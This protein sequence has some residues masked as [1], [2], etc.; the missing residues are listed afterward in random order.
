[1]DGTCTISTWEG[2]A[3][4]QRRQATTQVRRAWDSAFTQTSGPVAGLRWHV[5]HRTWAGRTA[6]ACCHSR[7]AYLPSRLPPTFAPTPTCA[8]ILGGHRFLHAPACPGSERTLDGTALA[9]LILPGCY[10]D[11]LSLPLPPEEQAS[12][13]DGIAVHSCAAMTLRRKHRYADLC[14]RTSAV[15]YSDRLTA[16]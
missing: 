16:A 3:R 2:Q 1:M 15:A 7:V 11:P 9:T 10:Q 13:H 8:G 14:C 5:L 6:A 4:W 12:T